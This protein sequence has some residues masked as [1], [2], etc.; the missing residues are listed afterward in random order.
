MRDITLGSGP[1]YG[2]Y[3]RY[4]DYGFD[5]TDHPRIGDVIVEEIEEDRY[6]LDAPF[7][8]DPAHLAAIHKTSMTKNWEWA[9]TRRTAGVSFDG[10]TRGLREREIRWAAGLEVDR[11]DWKDAYDY[12]DAGDRPV[13]HEALLVDGDGSS[14]GE[15]RIASAFGEVLVP[16]VD[17]W[18]VLVNARGDEYDDVGGTFS[19]QVASRAGISRQ[20]ALRAAWSESARPPFLGHLH[21]T[22]FVRRPRACLSEDDCRQLVRTYGGNP[23]LDPDRTEHLGAGLLANLGPVSMSFDWFSYRVSD[24]SAVPGTQSIV[25]L[26]LAG[27]TLPPGVTI[28]EKNGVI[29]SIRGGYSNS[30]EI[31]ASGLDLRA[32]V[33]QEMS[34]GDLGVDVYWSH[35]LDYEYRVLGIP[36]S[37]DRPRN[38]LHVATSVHRG[39]V[40]ATWAILARSRVD[41]DDDRYGGWIGHDLVVDWDDAF[42]LQGLALAGGVLNIADR[43]PVT[44]S[45]FDDAPV[46]EWESARGR[47][48]FVGLRFTPGG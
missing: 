8:Q 41:N 28:T 16:L 13:S 4:H 34:W 7:S 2:A 14:T 46:V 30:G 5:Q 47:T 6:R 9:S 37:S 10:Q 40:T 12:R 43:Q 32:H 27:Q 18:D 48:F 36:Q 23:E 44:N 42:G 3:A 38:R 31:E 45:A 22:P 15:R 26:H 39:G 24:L 21:Y 20:L 1:A 17:G 29:D 35:E 33:T 11:E 25:D 19:Y